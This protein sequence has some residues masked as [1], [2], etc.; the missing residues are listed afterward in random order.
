[1]Q[2]NRYLECFLF[3]C[4]NQLNGSFFDSVS[5]P[6]AIILRHNL[7]GV[8]DYTGKNLPFQLICDFL[9]YKFVNLFLL[10]IDY[11]ILIDTV[12][13]L[14][15]ISWIIQNICFSMNHIYY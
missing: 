11:A 10:L 4:L 8:N 9:S 5:F 6:K 15:Y 2:T 3:D 7:N 14:I 13:L 1:M 12:L